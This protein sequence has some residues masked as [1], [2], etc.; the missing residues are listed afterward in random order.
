[1]PLQ[2]RWQS[3]MTD[4]APPEESLFDQRNSFLALL[5]GLISVSERLLATGVELAAPLPPVER[6]PSRPVPQPGPLLR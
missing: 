1:M 6:E 5:L 3:R 4:P 2:R